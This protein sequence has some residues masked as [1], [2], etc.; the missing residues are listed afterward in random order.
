MSTGKVR[1][2]L[3]AATAKRK[4]SSREDATR[5][6]ADAGDPSETRDREFL[7]STTTRAEVISDESITVVDLFCGCGGLSLGIAEAAWR[8]GRSFVPLLACDIEDNQLAVYAKN[9]DSRAIQKADLSQ[10]S[11]LIGTAP[12]PVELRL[13]GPLKGK[14]VDFLLAG[15]PCQGHSNLNNH[16]RRVDPKNELYNKVARAAEYLRPRFIL[17][18]NVPGVEKDHGAAVERTALSLQQL[19]YT[20]DRRVLDLSL[21]GVPQTRKRHVML[22]IAHE[23]VTH[24]RTIQEIADEYRTPRRSLQWAISDLMSVEVGGLMNETS[25]MAEETRRRVDYLFEHNKYELPDSERPDCHR[26]KAHTY[27]SVYG[28]MHWDLPAPTITGGFLT[29][30]RGRFVHPELRRTLSPREAARVQFFPDFFDFSPLKTRKAIAEVIGNAVP[31]KMSMI[32]A[33]ALLEDRGVKA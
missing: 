33:L 28:R 12:T 14:R 24:R 11:S 25:E 32:F 13:F 27:G 9:F 31:P 18:E 8:L 1:R 23:E 7:C 20:T 15:P 17:I 22:A 4:K 2:N 29:V 10:L 16:T 3:S 30:G 21:L 26:T 5:Q 6:V 19:G